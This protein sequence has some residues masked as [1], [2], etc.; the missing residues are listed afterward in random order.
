M[1]NWLV[2]IIADKRDKNKLAERESYL[3]DIL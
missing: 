2:T 1:D 3:Y